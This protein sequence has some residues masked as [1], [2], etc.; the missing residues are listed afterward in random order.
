[1]NLGLKGKIESI[2]RELQVIR[3][4][5][6]LP[7]ESKGSEVFMKVGKKD[8]SFL[9][10]LTAAFPEG[11]GKGGEFDIQHLYNELGV[12]PNL[13]T[14]SQLIDL[15]QDSRW[16]VPEIFRDAIRKGLRTSPF[17]NK[18]IIG[19]ET[20]AQPQVNM[21]YIDLSDAEPVETEEA[22]SASKGTIS[23]GNKTVKIMKQ[24]MGINIT[25]EAIQYTSINLLTIFIQ[26]IGIKLGQKLNTALINILINGDQEDGS[27]SA[28][29]VGVNNTT[30]GVLYKDF[31]YGWIRGSRLGRQ[32]SSIIAGEVMANK[33]L[34][35]S[36]FKQ[37]QQGTPLQNIVVNETLPNQS[38]LYVSAQV[39]ASKMIA[40]D[41]K[42]AAVQLT[43]APL[44]VEGDKLVSKQ[45][46]ETV[47]SITTGFAN[48]FRDARYVLDESLVNAYDGATNDFPSYMTPT[49]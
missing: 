33:I 32:Y 29:V 49:L 12:N 24:T 37:K 40:L 23:Y 41:P 36:E 27:E 8:I 5:N 22:E 39:P 44:L 30:T 35:L 14:V 18:L 4:G 9:E 20:V 2:H 6:L 48:V 38:Q 34:E 10:Y 1:M 15:D 28:A 42:F 31:L 46:Q 21:P 26:D 43:S 3:A 11:C 19:N 47:A 17:Y 13:M 7:K 16:L 45:I 25:Y